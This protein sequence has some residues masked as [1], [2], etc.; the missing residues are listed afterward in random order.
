MSS[1]G[2]EMYKDPLDTDG[3]DSYASE[4]YVDEETGAPQV[5][6][7]ENNLEDPHHQRQRRKRYTV[8]P[9]G[10]VGLFCN[11]SDIRADL[12]WAQ[13]AAPVSRRTG[14]DRWA[15]WTAHGERHVRGDGGGSASR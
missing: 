10:I 5:I 2:G 1:Q 9:F 13:D 7:E 4:D 3:E 8:K 12:R 15:R 14:P 11:L 6:I